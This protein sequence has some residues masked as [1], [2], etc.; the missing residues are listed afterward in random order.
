ME[1][2]RTLNTPPH[3]LEAEK[4]ILGSMLLSRPAVEQAME[5]L[6]GEDFYLARHQDIFDAIRS[7]Y[8]RG[9]A[10]DSVTVID[11]LDRAGVI[12][13]GF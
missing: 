2:V 11:A 10:V 12:T 7:L 13:T 3:S 9:E 4:S 1:E 5:T 8:E 6:R